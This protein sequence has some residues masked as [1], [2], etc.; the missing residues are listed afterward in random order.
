MAAEPVLGEINCTPDRSL[1]YPLKIL[2]FDR[3]FDLGGYI[4]QFGHRQLN[5]YG[6]LILR[7]ES[8]VIF[9][10]IVLS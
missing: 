2:F 5:F 1:V 10:M 9:A 6:E 4:L 7:A 8:K 3:I